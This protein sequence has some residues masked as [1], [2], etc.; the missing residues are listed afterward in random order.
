[1]TAQIQT[2]PVSETSRHNGRLV[3]GLILIGAGILVALSNLNVFSPTLF[4]GALA[5]IFLVA[6]LTTNRFGL[7]IPGSILSGLT[8]G[9]ALIE[10]PFVHFQDPFRGGIFML[11]F[12]GGFALIT[13]LSAFFQTRRSILWGFLVPALALGLMGSVMVAGGLQ[14]LWLASYIWPAILILVGIALILR[15]R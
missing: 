7:V 8:A 12:A 14:M 4:L 10:G 6:G 3:A 9:I 2:N 15:R 1:M 13:I 11:A 5:A